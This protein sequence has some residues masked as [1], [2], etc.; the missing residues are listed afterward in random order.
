MNRLPGAEEIDLRSDQTCAHLCGKAINE[1]NG[2][3]DAVIMCLPRMRVIVVKLPSAKR[4]T[5]K[6]HPFHNFNLKIYAYI[7][8]QSTDNCV[9]Q[10]NG[11]RHHTR[12]HGDQIAN[13]IILIT[14]KF[15]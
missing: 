1:R 8:V 15:K 14:V 10:G 2:R 3:I 12:I 4:C 7:V 13:Y 5:R 9:K 11:E 6:A